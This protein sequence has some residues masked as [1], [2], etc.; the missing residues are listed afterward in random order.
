[1]KKGCLVGLLLLMTTA[2]SLASP[3]AETP[4]AAPKDVL[5]MSWDELVAAAKKEGQVTLYAWYKQEYFVDAFNKFKQQ[6]G[7]DAKVII[8]DRVGN[9]NKALAEKDMA[10]GT[11]DVMVAGGDSVK[12]MIETGMMLGPLKPRI[13]HADKLT[14]LLWEKQEGVETKGYL[15]PF[16]RNQTGLLYDPDK[17]KNPPKTWEELTAFVDANPKRFGFNDPSKG[18]SGQAFILTLLK[19]EAG[20]LDKYYGDTT[21]EEA[22]VATWGKAWDWVNK[23]KDKLVFTSSNNDSIQRVNDGELWLTVAWDDVAITQMN[24]GAL[25][26]RAK[27]FIPPMGFAGGGDTLGVLK[28][29]PHKAAAVLLVSFLT[30]PDQQKAL[31]A[32]GLYPA[33]TDVA[34]TSTLLTEEER[35]YSIPWIPAQYKAKFIADFVK[36]CLMK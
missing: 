31:N 34:V 33:R 24:T 19:Y 27:L 20:G 17:V 3:G 6:Y 28:N 13:A 14:P 12:P 11:I 36:N 32:V 30:E 4:A 16:M 35:K 29:A 15:V 1:M 8:G 2:L 7:I 21:V 22:D 23:R 9:F 26:K 5:Q 10:T 18:G 25:F